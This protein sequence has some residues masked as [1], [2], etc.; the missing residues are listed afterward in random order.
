MGGRWHQSSI[1][2]PPIP[3]IPTAYFEKASS[4]N[5][6]HLNHVGQAPS[7]FPHIPDRGRPTFGVDLAEQMVR[8]N[9][10]LPPIM[11]KCC[12][13]IEKYGLRS[14]GI[15]R[16][17]GTQR[18]VNLLKERLDKGTWNLRKPCQISNVP[19]DL[20][21][22]DLDA[23]EWASDINNVTS[24]I[25]AW[26][27][28]L[29]DPLM[30]Y[31]LHQGF[32]DAASAFASYCLLIFYQCCTEIENDRL[33]HIRLHERVNDLPDPNYATL[34][35]F[36][37]HLHKYVTRFRSILVVLT[38]WLFRISQWEAEN[39]MSIQNL[40][41]VFGPTLFGQVAPGTDVNGQANGGMADAG[42]QNKVNNHL[43]VLNNMDL[44]LYYRPFKLY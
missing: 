37:G 16:I 13:A 33:R 20:E 39:S 11:E 26:F 24:A 4:S 21:S 35:Y 2:L 5:H 27:R 1:Q 7:S 42:H 8:D 19:T 23:D 38:S 10:D 30:T 12:Q 31:I 44:M 29:P 34:K 6:G 36:L 18:K 25:K 41:I 32:I 14:Q 28:E 15:Y 40:S 3:T 43:N 17:N 22:V 9:V